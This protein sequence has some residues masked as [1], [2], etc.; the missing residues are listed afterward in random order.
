MSDN[1]DMSTAIR[2]LE[3]GACFFHMK[4]LSMD[5]LWGIWQH[6]LIKRVSQRRE[7]EEAGSMEDVGFF[8]ALEGIDCQS[9]VNGRRTKFKRMREEHEESKGNQKTNNE[10]LKEKK[11]SKGMALAAEEEQCESK[12]TVSSR[13][14][15]PKL[16]W[17]DNGLHDLFMDVIRKIGL[18]N[19]TPAKLLK[20]MN[21]PGI[22]VQQVTSHLQ[23]LRTYVRSRNQ[24]AAT[25]KKRGRKDRSIF[26]VPI[27]P[28]PKT[29]HPFSQSDIAPR[30]DLSQQLSRNRRQEAML[31]ARLPATT[32]ENQMLPFH[33][34][35][36]NGN[37]S[38]IFDMMLA[39]DWRMG[40]SSSCIEPAGRSDATQMIH[41]HLQVEPRELESRAVDDQRML[42][43]SAQTQNISYLGHVGSLDSS[44][45]QPSMENILSSPGVQMMNNVEPPR[46]SNSLNRDQ[47]TRA[48]VN[49]IQ[50]I[51][52]CPNSS[53]NQDQPTRTQADGIQNVCD[54]G[55]AGHCQNA[56]LMEESGDTL[57]DLAGSFCLDF[58]D[59]MES[60][61]FENSTSVPSKQLDGVDFD[62]VFSDQSM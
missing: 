60:P 19:A 58:N 24:L 17:E 12:N 26:N 31:H 55:G 43:L 25:M 44:F 57:D 18:E 62:K 8:K 6:V 2:V 42:S 40:A 45:Q 13:A 10:D 50:N 5:A 48:P 30:I 28:A 49:G 15:K 1:I 35:R 21:V 11:K 9:L 61:P 38:G 7:T 29:S 51:C 32:H 46:P 47:P 22:T 23:R 54:V 52:P 36:R 34:Q 4:P 33:A 27:G 3:N 14:K 16:C 20:L 59:L 56:E 37:L 39:Q 53:L 41:P